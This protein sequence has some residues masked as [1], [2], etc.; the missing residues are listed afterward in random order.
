[1]SVND[2]K[3]KING[4]LIPGGIIHWCFVNY[5]EIVI[6]SYSACREFIFKKG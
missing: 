2:I 5:D 4:N 6:T 3:L 1:M